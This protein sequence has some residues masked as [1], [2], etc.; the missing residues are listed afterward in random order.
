MNVTLIPG[1]LRAEDLNDKR[2]HDLFGNYVIKDFPPWQNYQ[3]AI[4]IFP[5]HIEHKIA[6]LLRISLPF[7]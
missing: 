5:T 1:Q 2:R 3:F 6:A 4:R 7:R